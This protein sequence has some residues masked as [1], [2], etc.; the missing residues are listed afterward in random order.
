MS[1][2]PNP[3]FDTRFATLAAERTSFRQHPADPRRPAYRKGDLLHVVIRERVSG[4]TGRPLYYHTVVLNNAGE[5]VDEMLQTCRSIDDA[6]QH[7][8]M[9]AASVAPVE[10]ARRAAT[11]DGAL[12]G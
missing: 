12:E 10:M 2:T 7:C 9:V 6:Y 8:R 4:S 1:T 11:A 5:V 3:T